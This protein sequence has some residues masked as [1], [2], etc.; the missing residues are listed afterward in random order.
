[1]MVVSGTGRAGNSTIEL[2]WEMEAETYADSHVE[3][4]SASRSRG[5]K[6][7]SILALATIILLMLLASSAGLSTAHPAHAQAQQDLGITYITGYVNITQPGYYELATNLSDTQSGGYCIGIFASNVTL[8][9]DGHMLNGSYS[10]IGVF[11]AS[12]VSNIII[13]NITIENYHYGIYDNSSNS[14]IKGALVSD[15]SVGIVVRADGDIVSNNTVTFTATVIYNNNNAD[16]FYH[17]GTGIE[18]YGDN[19]SILYNDIQSVVPSIHVELASYHGQSRGILVNGDN[20]TILG[21]TLNESWVVSGFALDLG[22]EGN[23]NVIARNIIGGGNDYDVY[24]SGSGNSLIGNVVSG[25]VENVYVSG[26]GNIIDKNN[27]YG[28]I[29]GLYLNGSDSEIF[30][31]YFGGSIGTNN[32]AIKL[33]GSNITIYNITVTGPP[34]YGAALNDIYIIQGKNIIIEDSNFSYGGDWGIYSYQLWKNTNITIRDNY[35]SH[36]GDSAIEVAGNNYTIADNIICSSYEGIYVEGSDNEVINNILSYNNK[37]VYFIGAYN[38]TLARNSVTANNVGLEIDASYGN[39]IFSNIIL[40]NGLGMRLFYSSR[41]LIYN[42][43]FD[44]EINT[45]VSNGFNYWNTTLQNGE[46]I[47]GGGVIGG[48]AWFDPQGN[49]FSQTAPPSSNNHYLCNEPF[50][51]NQNNTDYLPL[52]GSAYKVVFI[53]SGL[54][55]GTIWS[56]TLEGITNSSRSDILTFMVPAGNYSYKVNTISG[57]SVSPSGGHIT[58]NSNVTQYMTFTA[59]TTITATSMSL[60]EILSYSNLLIIAVVMVI[61]IAVSVIILTLSKRNK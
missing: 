55:A 9:G 56:V 8:N 37:G 7:G 38:N 22:V 33:S 50:V 21:N 11:A 58:V 27:V 15:S 12:N 45:N 34:P 10:G 3:E 31:D 39:E 36:I 26:S 42:N 47:V 49:G 46:N 52:R 18:I 40:G 20:N 29:I 53:E 44:N 13:E 16:I 35:F 54:P 23:D 30:D 57:Y 2:A 48:N 41:N 19:N 17:N 32:T 60:G 28:F 25:S 24:V 59:T 43:L 14:A 51:I 61:I 5:S 1:M 4:F 6:R